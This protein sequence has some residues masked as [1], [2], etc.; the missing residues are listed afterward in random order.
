[1]E[2][3]VIGVLAAVAL[4]MLCCLVVIVEAHIKE[5]KEGKKDK[6]R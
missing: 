6:E 1:M 3:W 5:S 2:T 4:F